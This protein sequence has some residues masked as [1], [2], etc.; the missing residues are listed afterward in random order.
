MFILSFKYHSVIYY[1]EA[2][3]N[4]GT[5]FEHPKSFEHD[6]NGTGVVISIEGIYALLLG[7]ALFIFD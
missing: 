4:L 6:T 5:D 3:W 1:A 7:I 2:N